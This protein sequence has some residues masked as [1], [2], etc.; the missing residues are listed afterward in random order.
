MNKYFDSLWDFRGVNTKEFTH[1]MHSYPAMMIPQV[2]RKLLT[3]Y[4]KSGDFVFDPYIGSGTT[5]VEANL[6]GLNSAGTDLN[7][8]SRMISSA[9]TT[10]LNLDILKDIVNKFKVFYLDNKNINFD[11]PV[12]KNINFWFKDGVIHD[13]SVIKGFVET[14]SDVSIKT[15]FNV[16]FSEVIRECSLCKNS[17]F[18]LVRI[19]SEKIINF[20]PNPFELMI[21]KIIKNTNGLSEFICR[22]NS[23]EEVKSDIYSFNTINDCGPLMPESVDLIITSPPYGDSKTTVAYGQFSRLSNQWLG[24]VD[25]NLLD[26]KL[27]GGSGSHVLEGLPMVR[28]LLDTLNAIKIIDAKRANEVLIFFSDYYR[29]IENVS[30]LLK[31]NKYVAYVVGNRTVRNY[32]IPMD[33]ITKDFFE[34]FGFEHVETIVREI[35]NKKMPKVNSPTNVSGVKSS[36]MNYEFIVVMKKHS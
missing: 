36:T 17:E 14:I 32:N 15:F 7:P 9:K 12:F 31:R 27:M 24:V 33:E 20:N 13:L 28:G 29:S 35:P 30:K 8:L 22:I 11:I 21:K 23:F 10:P 1:C 26:N 4:S 3:K 2:A 16:C 34:L 18:K 5:L 25:A 6:L 19:K